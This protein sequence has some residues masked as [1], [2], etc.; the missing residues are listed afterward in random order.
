MC[1]CMCSCVCACVRVRVRV[2]VHVR[3]RVRMCM[4]VYVR[5][6][7]SAS[8]CVCI[9]VC[10]SSPRVNGKGIGASVGD[11]SISVTCDTGNALNRHLSDWSHLSYLRILLIWLIHMSR[12]SLLS[13]TQDS[14]IRRT[15]HRYVK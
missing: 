5:M 2:R 10:M 14:L 4:R 7:V 6:C 13:D 12:D 3:V 11:N 8:V 15:T 9:C 1:S